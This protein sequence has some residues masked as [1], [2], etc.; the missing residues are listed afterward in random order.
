MKAVNKNIY[1]SLS[2]VDLYVQWYF[3]WRVLLYLAMINKFRR[4][5]KTAKSNY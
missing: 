2:Y 1:I 5:R 4:F 3:G